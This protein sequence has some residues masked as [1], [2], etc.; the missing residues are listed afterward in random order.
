MT[1]NDFLTAQGLTAEEIAAVVGNEK[2]TKALTA[3][4]AKFDEGSAALTAAQAEKQETA[5]FWEQKTAELQN[6]VT[7]LTAAEKRAATAEAERARVGAYMKSLAEQGYDVPKDMYE[8]A[9]PV[10]PIGD[11]PDPSKYLTREDFTKETRGIAPNLVTLVGLQAEYQDLFGTPYVNI[12]QDFL[13]A[14]KSGKSLRD[15]TRTKYNFDAKRQEKQQ[16]AEKVRI[17][18]LVAEQ[19]K[20][21]EAELAAKYGT[22]SNTSI[23]M[24]SKFD[25]LEK[26]PGFKSD[27]WK[28]AEGR[29]TNREARLKKFENMPLQ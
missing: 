19:L 13:E 15:Y 24:P 20:T 29:K 21:K 10:K 3:A 14:Q 22:N 2:Q 1:I 16:A 17:D 25:K 7:R 8:G 12:D 28:T 23:A 9:A 11:P 6:G 18:G 4:L 26:Q 27:S 5:T